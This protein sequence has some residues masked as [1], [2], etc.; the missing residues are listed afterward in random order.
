MRPETVVA[1]ESVMT[2][3]AAEPDADPAVEPDADPDVAAVG[4]DPPIRDGIVVGYDGSPSSAR[5]LTWAVTE[6]GLRGVPVHVVRAWA[7]VTV[8][9]Q[10][11]APP[12]VVPS[13]ADCR[14]AVVADVASAVAHA[15]TADA[16]ATVEHPPVVHSH[17][18]EGPAAATLVDA[19]RTADLVVVGDRGLGG[20][21]GLVLG[22]VSDQVVRHAH[23]TV[24]VVRS[25]D[26]DD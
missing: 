6:A 15:R 9:G 25:H 12:G 11:D 17:V 10:V 5:A 4:F 16:S 3:E 26:R 23:C 18:V 19:S 20:F 14:A 1:T 13:E 2:S 8:I 22:S 24:V 21:W 7:L